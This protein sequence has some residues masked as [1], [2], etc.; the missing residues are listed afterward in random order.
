MTRRLPPGL[1]AVVAAEFVDRGDVTG[2]QPVCERA[3]IDRAVAARSGRPQV[4]SVRLGVNGFVEL[5]PENVD[6][7]VTGTRGT[8]HTLA[9]DGEIANLKFG[10]KK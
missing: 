1:I 5:S 6:R 3:S 7:T 8:V 10:T 4:L 2:S 9:K